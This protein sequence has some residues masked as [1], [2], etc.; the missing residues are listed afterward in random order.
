MST[1]RSVGR[2]TA[3]QDKDRLTATHVKVRS[4]STQ[5]KV[6][7]AAAPKKDRSTNLCAFTFADGRQCRTPRRSGHLH[8]CYFHAQKE[9]E[10][11]A[12]QQVGQDICRFLPTKLLTACDLGVAMSRLFCAVAQGQVKPKVASTLAYL[13]QTMLQSIPIAR[14]EYIESF[15]TN[16]WRN[17]V[18]VSFRYEDEANTSAPQPASKPPASPV[19]VPTAKPTSSPAPQH[20]AQPAP[21][22]RTPLPPTTTIGRA[23]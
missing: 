13:A 1:N 2:F 15:N 4:A 7:P 18:R 20:S 8:L 23:S 5:E 14:H 11:L 16:T 17:A 3:T 22:P 12:A 6:R 21:S 19:S 9:A 10:S